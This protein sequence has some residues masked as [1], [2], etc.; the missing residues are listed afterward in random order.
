MMSIQ[1][2]PESISFLLPLLFVFCLAAS[3]LASCGPRGDA[4]L[5]EWIDDLAD[6][7]LSFC[8]HCLFVINYLTRLAN[9]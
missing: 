5:C 9:G 3:R 4:T 8:L 1:I 6:V 7:E 2:L